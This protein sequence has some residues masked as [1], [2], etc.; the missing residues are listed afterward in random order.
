MKKSS[1]IIIIV[2][3]IIAILIG[4]TFYEHNNEQNKIRIGNSNFEIPNGFHEG[5]LNSLG[6]VNLTNNTHSIFLAS[7]NQSKI[8]DQINGLKEYYS[9]I[10]ET[11]SQ[12]NFKVD[13]VFVYNLEVI[14]NT[15]SSFNDTNSKFYWF[16]KNNEIFYIYTW[17]GIP[18]MDTIV[19][20]F[21][22]TMN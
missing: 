21:I 11:T 18:N 7:K 17:D 10:N 15:N 8:Q 14:D 16:E 3:I 12:K 2:L 22:K 4:Y 5:K 20:N 19:S 6:D 1:I 9:N 13:E